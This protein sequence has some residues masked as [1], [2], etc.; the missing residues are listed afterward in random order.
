MFRLKASICIACIKQVCFGGLVIHLTRFGL[1]CRSLGIR[2]AL[3]G[4]GLR[5][6]QGYSR[7]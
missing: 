7:P 2:H 5:G 1:G 4:L 3:G 6:F